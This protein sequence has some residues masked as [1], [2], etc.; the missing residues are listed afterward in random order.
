VST[1]PL[2]KFPL[3]DSDT[4]ATIGTAV[5]LSASL[6]TTRISG[7][8][9]FEAQLTTRAAGFDAVGLVISLTVIVLSYVYCISTVI[10]YGISSCND[11]GQVLPS[12]TSDT[13]ATIGAAVQLSAS[14]VTTKIFVAGTSK[15]HSTLTATGFDAV[16]LVISFNCNCLG[17]VYR[18]STIIRY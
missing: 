18:V 17:Y 15:I 7:A 12:D 13:N 1:S 8:G 9:T 11:S 5:Q 2:Q 16:G 3:D 6:V 4:N 14:S 10:S